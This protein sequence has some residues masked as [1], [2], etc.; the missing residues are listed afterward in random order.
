MT[1]VDVC[2]TRST[3]AAEVDARY[4]VVSEWNGVG[5]V[6]I[7]FGSDGE[8]N[9]FGQVVYC[10]TQAVVRGAESDVFTQNRTCNVYVNHENNVFQLFFMSCNVCF[11][12]QQ[13]AFLGA[14]P[15]EFHAAFWLVF[16]EVTHQFHNN[17]RACTVVVHAVRE[18]NGVVVRTEYDGACFWIGT[19]DFSDHV[20]RGCQTFVLNESQGHS[21]RFCFYQLMSIH[22]SHVHARDLA[23]FDCPVAEIAGI[24]IGF[25]AFV[26]DVAFE[27]DEGSYAGF[28]QFFVEFIAHTAVNHNDFA[29]GVQQIHI[30]SILN[31]SEWSSDAFFRS[32]TGHTVTGYFPLFAASYQRHFFDVP[33]VYVE[34]FDNRLGADRTSF[35][36]QD[37]SCLFFFFGAAG[38]DEVDL[39]QQFEFTFTTYHE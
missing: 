12:A 29:F 23:F 7:L 11:G 19:F 15:A 28:H 39:V 1:V 20:L 10:Y 38:A 32:G 30:G 36:S 27:G 2:T 5:R 8:T 33:A 22:G 3:E 35:L 31:V 9:F 14:V 18:W 17:Y 24:Q 25:F 34:G 6:D 13:T 26:N 21:F 16:F 37:L 4:A